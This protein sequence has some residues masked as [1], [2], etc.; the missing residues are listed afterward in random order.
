MRVSTIQLDFDKEYGTIWALGAQYG[1]SELE[2]I[3][4]ANYLGSDLG[5]D[6]ISAGV[7]IGC[8]CGNSAFLYVG[9]FAMKLRNPV[10]SGCSCGYVW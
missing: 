1:I 10:L 5:L 4:E 3:I 9:N 7:T 8:T 2:T 6:I